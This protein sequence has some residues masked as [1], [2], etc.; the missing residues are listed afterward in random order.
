M[1]HHDSKDAKKE[2]WEER[3]TQQK[4]SGLSVKAFCAQGK[5]LPTTFYWWKS[6]LN[7]EDTQSDAAGFV[8]IIRMHHIPLKEKSLKLHPP[9]ICHI[10][11]AE[12]TTPAYI[13]QVVKAFLEVR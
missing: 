13:A 12:G 9:G 6:K 7:D 8:E 1:I 3:I 2:H 4:R 11:I 10:E 5:I